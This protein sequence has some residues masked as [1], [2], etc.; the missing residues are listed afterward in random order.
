MGKVEDLR[1]IRDA[2]FAAAQVGAPARVATASRPVV[3]TAPVRVKK[4]GSPTPAAVVD[5][6]LPN[7]SPETTD[8]LCG[9]RAIS[10]KT[11]IRSRGHDEQNHKY[12]KG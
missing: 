10:G 8:Q 1:A 12:P 6:L 4:S 11:C 2:R 9:H 3:A 5:V 7:D